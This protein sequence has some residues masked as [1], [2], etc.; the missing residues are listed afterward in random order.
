MR[1][2]VDLLRI[3]MGRTMLQFRLRPVRQIMASGAQSLI[4]A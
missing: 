4:R 1:L 2:C 3:V